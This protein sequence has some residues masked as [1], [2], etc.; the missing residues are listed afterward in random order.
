MRGH[1]DIIRMRLGGK[2]PKFVFIN[3]YQCKTDWF[4]H[5]DHA[6]V[7]T[8]GDSVASIDLRFVRGLSVSIS[9]LTERR[10]KAIAEACKLAGAAV[11]A[12]CSGSEWAEVWRA[13]EV[14]HG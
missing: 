6:T 10:A 1:E 4:E 14:S 5:H 8:A 12:A 9:A 7:C 13:E 2:S 3:D 11:V